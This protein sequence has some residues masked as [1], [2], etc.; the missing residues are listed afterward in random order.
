[1]GKIISAVEKIS[2]YNPADG[3]T[4]QANLISPDE[5][6]ITAENLSNNTGTGVTFG[7]KD[8]QAAV[9]FMDTE[10]LNQIESW[11][12]DGSGGSTKVNM[13]V[14]GEDEFLLMQEL[15][16]IK[17]TREIGVD[18]RNGANVHVAN[19]SHVGYGPDIYQ[20]RNLINAGAGAFEV[21]DDGTNKDYQIIFPIEGVQL[22]AAATYANHVTNS[23]LRIRFIDFGG[24]TI[25]QFDTTINGNGRFSVTA[26]V[27]ANTYS[28]VV[29]FDVDGVFAPGDVTDRT[30]RLGTNG[31]F[32][33][34]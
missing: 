25:S 27:P 22:T 28:V 6:E 18:A 3:V 1:M 33:T 2:F 24:I 29:F 32:T 30:I 9:G 26:E 16:D 10:G 12:D 31:A 8:F 23:V 34:D 19:I 14:A 15:E 4:V 17:L 13:A 5:T 20:Q 7:G 11:Q 21:F